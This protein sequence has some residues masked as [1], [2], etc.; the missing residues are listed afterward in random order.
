MHNEIVLPSGVDKN[1]IE[2]QLDRELS[3]ADLLPKPTLQIECLTGTIIT[4]CICRTQL[5]LL[6]FQKYG[7]GNDIRYTSEWAN[8]PFNDTSLTTFWHE[9]TFTLNESIVQAGLYKQE[10]SEPNFAL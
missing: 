3:S 8:F 7:L 2:N 1:G 5:S 9:A 10:T 6:Q 4:S